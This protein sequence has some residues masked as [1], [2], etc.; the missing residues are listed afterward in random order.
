MVFDYVAG[1]LDWLSFALPVEGKLAD[2]V[3]IGK[4]ARRDVP[5]C[6]LTEKASE[7]WQRLHGTGW[8]VC[9]VINDARVVLGLVRNQAQQDGEPT[10]DRI[11]QPGPTT[12]RPYLTTEQIADYIRGKDSD[13]VLVTTSDGRLVGALSEHDLYQ[14]T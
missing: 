6:Y 8:Q 1:K 12:F 5:T 4:L 9:V 11:M 10:V 7:V 14:K 3:T 2:T 13:T